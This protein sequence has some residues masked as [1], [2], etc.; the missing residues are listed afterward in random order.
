MKK[1]KM[2]LW[3]A[4]TLIGIVAII[5]IY[6]NPCDNCWS[7]VEHN[8]GCWTAHATGNCYVSQGGAWCITTWSCSEG[9]VESFCTEMNCKCY[10]V[11]Y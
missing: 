5:G 2:R 3:L 7:P 4:A 8:D 9:G 11:R 6:A 10:E 1:R